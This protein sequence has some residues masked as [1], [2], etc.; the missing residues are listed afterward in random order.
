MKKFKIMLLG[1]IGVGKTSLVR[2]LVDNQFSA[3]YGPT[4]GVDVYDYVVDLS[5]LDPD[6]PSAN[7]TPEDIDADRVGLAIWDTDGDFGESIFRHSYITGADGALIVGDAG[8]PHTHES[9]LK[10][11]EAFENA[12]PGRPYFFVM[13]KLDLLDDANILQ[14]PAALLASE[15]LLQTSAKTGDNVTEAFFKTADTIVRRGF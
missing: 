2:R 4:M 11:G 15:L 9:M 1:E 12:L 10:L 7:R 13:N 6:P 8:R 5:V 14:L 3:D